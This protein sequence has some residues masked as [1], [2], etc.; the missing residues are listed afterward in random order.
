MVRS[1]SPV[2]LDN[3]DNKERSV[4]PVVQDL[5]VSVVTMVSRAG[6]VHQDPLDHKDLV[7]VPVQWASPE[8]PET[9]VLPVQPDSPVTLDN[10]DHKVPGVL[11]DRKESLVYQVSLDL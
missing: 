7:V 8:T 1:V 4:T 10:K 6:P 9:E 5:K 11:L 2:S 3:L